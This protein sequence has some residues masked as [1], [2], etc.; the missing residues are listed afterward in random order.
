MSDTTAIFILLAILFLVLAI[1]L[2]IGMSLMVVTFIGFVLIIEQPLIQ[3]VIS[4]FGLWNSFIMTAIP[5]FVFMG[6]IFVSCGI[7]RYLFD[8]V[9]AWLGQLPGGIA[10]SVVGGCAIF[11]A[12]SGSS[13]ATAAALG[14]ISLPEMER[15]K[16]DP[17]LALGTV[18]AGGTLGILIPPSIN[19]ILFGAWTNTSVVHLFAAGVIPGILLASFFAI[20]IILRVIMNPSLAPKPPKI[21]WERRLR[22][23]IGMA[24]WFLT[25]LLILGVIFAGIM[26][27]TEAAALGSGIAI[28]MGLFYRRLTWKTLM[29][30]GLTATKVT[31]MIG[32]VAAA[33]IALVYVVGYMSMPELV[34]NF[35]T[36]LP[37]GKYGILIMITIMYIIL[38]CFF[39]PVSMMLLT[40]PFVTPLVKHLGYDL[41][42][43]GV[44]L[45]ILSEMAFLT[46]PVGMNLYIIHGVSPK[47]SVMTIAYGALPFLVP[48]TLILLV[49]AI[50]PD[51]ALWLPRVMI[52]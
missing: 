51:F 21:T 33:S 47:H 14:S 48:M 17:K 25:I 2:E 29:D 28:V 22:A 40:L 12:M 52:G 38:G 50:W 20:Y 18:A 3:V 11:A 37:V 9:D 32:L 13:L 45:V 34:V 49:L 39:D 35:F 30:A 16:Y 7:T 8:A 26:T 42:W 4:G 10:L 6:A 15:Y 23:T 27:P 5:M 43:F 1:G 41:I 31:A 44:Y 46:P 36:A 19:M 24:P